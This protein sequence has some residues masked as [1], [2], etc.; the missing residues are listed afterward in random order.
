LSADFYSEKTSLSLDF[1]SEKSSLSLDFYSEKSSLS[2]DFYSEN[3]FVAG[4]LLRKTYLSVDLL[5]AKFIS[6]FFMSWDLKMIAHN[7]GFVQV[8]QTY[9]TQLLEYYF[10]FVLLLSSW[11]SIP[12]PAQS[13]K[14]LGA[15]TGRHSTT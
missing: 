9:L 7:I 10:S 12:P 14:P 4:L 13:R 8:G 2:L 3:L 1:Y 15:T 5:Y 11:F 6:P